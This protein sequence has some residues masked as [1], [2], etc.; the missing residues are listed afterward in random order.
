MTVQV[1]VTVELEEDV[2][3]SRRVSRMST[4]TIRPQNNV[5]KYATLRLPRPNVF[6]LIVIRY[7]HLPGG[8]VSASRYCDM[9]LTKVTKK[10]VAPAVY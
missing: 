6:S 4:T 9:R 3:K 5:D 8:F 1:P 10:T 2:T 7:S